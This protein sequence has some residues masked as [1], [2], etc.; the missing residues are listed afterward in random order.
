[1]SEADNGGKTIRVPTF[2]GDENQ[3]QKWQMRFRAYAKL[4]GFS[5]TLQETPEADLP[6]DSAEAEALTGSDDT[7][8]KQ[9]KA[10]LYNDKAIASFTL[11]FTID[12]LLNMVMESQTN[13]W[14]DG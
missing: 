14:P 6:N 8:Q 2:D 7:V 11:A 10:V 12:E 13:E 5:K 3:Y 4:V 9:K 1:M